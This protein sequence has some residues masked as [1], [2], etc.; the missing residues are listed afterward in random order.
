MLNIPFILTTFINT[1]P[2]R[3]LG[4]RWPW[5]RNSSPFGSSKRTYI[6]FAPHY[7]M[8][9]YWQTLATLDLIF[10][11]PYSGFL[12][13]GIIGTSSRPVNFRSV[14]ILCTYYWWWQPVPNANHYIARTFNPRQACRSL[15]LSFWVLPSVACLKYPSVPW[16]FP[17]HW[18]E[19]LQSLTGL[20]LSAF[21]C[22]TCPSVHQP[23]N[24][25]ETGYIFFNEWCPS[26][27]AIL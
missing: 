24:A 3:I 15:A 11:T 4:N 14:D 18:I 10:N 7:F 23:F 5:G 26:L 20:D 22:T 17:S 27:L 25:V 21:F 12:P 9:S 16:T 8:T 6:V 19:T 1:P 2:I 13:P